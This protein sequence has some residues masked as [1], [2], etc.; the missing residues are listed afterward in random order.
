MSLSLS[1]NLS[2]WALWIHIGGKN[3]KLIR[4]NG[5]GGNAS[6]PLIFFFF[7][8]LK[9]PEGNEEKDKKNQIKKLRLH[10]GSNRAEDDG[11]QEEGEVE[12]RRWV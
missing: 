6:S 11:K 4:C 3:T 12:P 1:P 2:G 5:T 8:A 7:V 10:V 9:V